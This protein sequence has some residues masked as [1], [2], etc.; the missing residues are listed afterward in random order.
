MSVFVKTD[1]SVASE[2]KHLAEET[3][4]RFG[5]IDVIVNNA[6]VLMKETNI[7]DTEESFWDKIFDVNVKGIFLTT[8][9]VAPIMKSA[10]HGIIINIGSA[11]G[12]RP[13][14][15]TVAY[16]ATKAAIINLTKDWLWI[17]TSHPG[18]LCLPAGS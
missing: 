17:S 18:Q 7:L 16:A 2:V 12:I 3:M 1:I 13:R 15:N 9:F 4:R 5:K 14:K 11:A 6:A 8:K 10:G